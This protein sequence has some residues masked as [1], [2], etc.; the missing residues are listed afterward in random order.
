MSLKSLNSDIEPL[1]ESGMTPNIPNF[2]SIF[3]VME[4][5]QKNLYQ[6]MEEV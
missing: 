3:L 5:G 2:D 6:R 4:L 1:Q